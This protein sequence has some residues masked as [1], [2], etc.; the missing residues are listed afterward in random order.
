MEKNLE[1][2]RKILEEIANGII[3]DADKLNNSVLSTDTNLINSIHLQ[4]ELCKF[5]SQ[6][7]QIC[8]EPKKQSIN[9]KMMN[10]NQW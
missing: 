7:V 2:Q 1:K 9:N 5:E 8:K 3:K 4:R 10:I 6:N